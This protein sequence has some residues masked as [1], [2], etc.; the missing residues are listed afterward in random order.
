MN[1]RLIVFSGLITAIVGAVFGL[2]ASE[3]MNPPYES[4]V[5]RSIHQNYV[6]AGAVIGLTVGM[7][8]E[9]VRQLKHQQE[10]EQQ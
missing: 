2:I 8:Q 4:D 5:Y 7:S 10:K 1:S 3:A 6:V 9:C